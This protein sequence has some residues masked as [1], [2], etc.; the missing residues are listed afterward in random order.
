LLFAGGF[1]AGTYLWLHAVT[2]V[3]RKHHGALSPTVMKLIRRIGGFIFALFALWI[4]WKMS[5]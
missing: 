1:G 3:V 4:L 5:A 2:N